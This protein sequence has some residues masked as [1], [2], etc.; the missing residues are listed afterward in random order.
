MEDKNEEAEPT[1][2]V[3]E[4]FDEENNLIGTEFRE[5]VHKKGLYHRAVNVFLLNSNGLILLQKRSPYKTICPSYWDL[6]VLYLFILFIC[7]CMTVFFVT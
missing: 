5:I 3:F 4:I 6:S 2:E 7:L 1:K